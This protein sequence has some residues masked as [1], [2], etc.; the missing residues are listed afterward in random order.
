MKYDIVQFVTRE[1]E[2]VTEGEVS[3]WKKTTTR[4]S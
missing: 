2:A 3:Q 1:N 4:R